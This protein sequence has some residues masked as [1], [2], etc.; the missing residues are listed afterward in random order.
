MSCTTGDGSSVV[1]NPGAGDC[2]ITNVPL[3]T[4]W[5]VETVPPGYIGSVDQAVTV[6][7]GTQPG[8]G[9]TQSFSLTNTAAT[10]TIIIEK[11]GVGGVALQGAV[12]E[13]YF[14][15]GLTA[16][17]SGE[18]RSTVD[19]TTTGQQCTS[20][21][22]GECTFS[23]LAPG[24]Y[25][26]VE[27]TAPNGYDKVADFQVNV[28]IGTTAGQ[29][30]TVRV[31]KSDPATPGTI[32]VTKR[33]DAGNALPGAEFTLYTDAAPTGGSRNAGG[34]TDPIT[35]NPVRKCTTGTGGTCSIQSVPLGKYW[36]VET[37]TP[38][39]HE[40]AA[41][42]AVEVGRGTTAPE[43]GQTVPVTIVDYRKH[44]VVVLV[45]HE[46]TDTLHSSGVTIGNTT[47]QSLAPGTLTPAQQKT[48][49]ETDGA[50][51]RD[52]EGHGSVS[53]TVAPPTHAVVTPAP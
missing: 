49:C 18:V 34:V 42:V 8:Q 53:V 50:N 29:G 39:H 3:G 11:S 10:G 17:T 51:F 4:Y 23:S 47:K 13:L 26:V 21:P 12:F 43:T 44:R 20:Q 14:D 36:I 37:V 9:Q 46:G 15:N 40:T 25:W 22:D 33:D 2:S 28:P 27:V 16:G 1:Q 5:I 30:A 35:A 48:L 32:A 38:A 6:G 52:L 41:D 45:C 31:P 19:D 7:L 24:H